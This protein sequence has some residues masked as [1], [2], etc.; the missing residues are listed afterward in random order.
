MNNFSKKYYISIR[1]LF[2]NLIFIVIYFFY[3]IG[4]FFVN[5]QK[6]GFFCAIIFIVLFFDTFIYS[7][8]NIR[9]FFNKRP[10]IEITKSYLIN[11]LNN[12]KIH[13]YDIKKISL[14]GVRGYDI[15]KLDLYNKERYVSQIDNLFQKIFYKIDSKNISV[16]IVLDFI[17]DDSYEIFEFIENHWKKK[18]S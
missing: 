17:K 16:R 13:W 14:I 1:L 7:L 5:N 2:H 8:K 18:T 6:I 15:L 11:H 9:L 4:L 3:S 12:T 10:A